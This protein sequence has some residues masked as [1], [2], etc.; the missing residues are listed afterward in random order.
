MSAVSD[1]AVQFTDS[2]FEAEHGASG[3]VAASSWPNS[4]VTLRNVTQMGPSV[5][6]GSELIY[7]VGY[8]GGSLTLSDVN[9]S[10]ADGGVILENLYIGDR[11]LYSQGRITNSRLVLANITTGRAVPP[12]RGLGRIEING[13]V[14]RSS[15]VLFR[16]LDCLSQRWHPATAGILFTASPSTNSNHVFDSVYVHI[17][18][19]TI[20]DEV[21]V[22]YTDD[23]S[24]TDGSFRATN[25][26]FQSDNWACGL[27]A[28]GWW[29]NTTVALRN[30]SQSG[31]TQLSG[32][33]I[34]Y[35]VGAVGGSFVAAHFDAR[36]DDAAGFLLENA[37]VAGL[38]SFRDGVLVRTTFIVR[39][40]TFA[41]ASPIVFLSRIELRNLTLRHSQLTFSH[42]QS[43]VTFN[44][45]ETKNVDF[46]SCVMSDTAV[47]FSNFNAT[48]RNGDD[49]YARHRARCRNG[50]VEWVVHGRRQRPH[51]P[52]ESPRWHHHARTGRWIERARAKSTLQRPHFASCEPQPACPNVVV[53]GY[54]SVDGTAADGT[55]VRASQWSIRDV[56]VPTRGMFLYVGHGRFEGVHS[57]TASPAE[58]R[59]IVSNISLGE[60]LS[61]SNVAVV[62][63]DDL[64]AAET[65]VLISDVSASVNPSWY[66]GV[67]LHRS[68]SV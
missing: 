41:D 36:A 51:K 32:R 35:S 55:P 5:L 21:N 15:T 58:A 23:S 3:I 67:L 17:N 43:D 62:Q 16:N 42:V 2:V 56:V 46:V 31:C 12:A 57:Y 54:V 39:R 40:V 33:T 53:F 47:L 49:D 11:L 22:K 14:F 18:G 65:A 50:L 24:V 34:T 48:M 25:C 45:R 66:N 27:M 29:R 68:V 30:V 63:I 13:V 37:T 8:V 1:G 59:V 4:S 38:V 26:S 20:P 7:R 52:T 28:L 44:S 6:S 19:G 60:G 64:W 9:S 10:R 61:V